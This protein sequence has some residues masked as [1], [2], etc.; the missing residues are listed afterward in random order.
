[1]QHLS[2]VTI[3]LD[4][5]SVDCLRQSWS[6]LIGENWEPLLCS[7]IGDVFFKVKAGTVWWLCTA[8]GSLE[9]VAASVLDFNFQLQGS[10]V[11]E[12]FLPGL[13][14]ALKRH[15]KNLTPHQCY[16]YFTLPL[17]QGGSYSVEN[18]HPEAVTDHF[19]RTGRIIQNIQSQP[20]GA[21]VCVVL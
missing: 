20:D 2:E 11:D 18:M 8:T 17:F 3:Y 7:A 10:Q 14:E 21:S 5:E 13:V 6:W 19:K 15:D 12:W 16:S 1:M 9:Q 4:D